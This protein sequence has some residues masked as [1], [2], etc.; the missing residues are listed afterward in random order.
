MVGSE[1]VVGKKEFK[2]KLSQYLMSTFQTFTNHAKNEKKYLQINVKGSILIGLIWNFRS[3]ACN[4][5][6]TS[7]CILH[8]DV[9][10]SRYTCIL[11]SLYFQVN[12]YR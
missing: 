5:F 7:P 1:P 12:P 4:D 10:E 2:N 6:F 8:N 9:H 3:R 11:F